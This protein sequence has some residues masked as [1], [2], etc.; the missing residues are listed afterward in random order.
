MSRM[1]TLQVVFLVMCITLQIWT[2]SLDIL[3]ITE[4]N[5]KC[6]HPVVC[7]R[8]DSAIDQFKLTFYLVSA[9]EQFAAWKTAR[10]VHG[11]VVIMA[12]LSSCQRHFTPTTS[13]DDFNITFCSSICPAFLSNQ[14]IFIHTV[15]NVTN[16]K[17]SNFNSL[18]RPDSMED[19]MRAI[20]SILNHVKWKTFV[21]IT[22]S[23][24]VLTALSGGRLASIKL[25]LYMID[26]PNNP[27]ESIDLASIYELLPV[28]D[29]N[30][31]VVCPFECIQKHLNQA[32]VLESNTS[33]EK[34][35][36]LSQWLMVP[37]AGSVMDIAHSRE[38]F[39]T[40]DVVFL[41][42]MPCSRYYLPLNLEITTKHLQTLGRFN[43][44]GQA[45]ETTGCVHKTAVISEVLSTDPTGTKVDTVGY[46]ASDGDV[47]V[48]HELY[49][50]RKYGFYNRTL[51]VGTLEWAPY[52]IKKVE[53]GSVWFDGLCIQLVKELA[54][55]LNFRQV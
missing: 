53:N 36:R 12:S 35:T 49:H 13:R 8:N 21:V 10:S 27:L 24:D 47:G 50:A 16:A 20:I 2:S 23:Y 9:Q 19:V 25:L 14:E 29:L 54:R 46:I 51:I 52:V 40:E 38:P 11:D 15:F 5:G 7:L 22:S 42:F 31:L 45:A 26:D 48:K 28:K 4:A 18:I 43:I 55:Q 34:S 33:V 30:L 41:E 1:Y 17:Q 3:L 32:H 6:P 37:S 44:T 39:K